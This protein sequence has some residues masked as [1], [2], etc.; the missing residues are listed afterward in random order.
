[1]KLFKNLILTL[2]ILSASLGNVTPASA[3]FAS[4]EEIASIDATSPLEDLIYDE[5][6]QNDYF[7]GL[8]RPS[9][10]GKLDLI[11][12][13]EYKFSNTFTSDYGLYMYLFNPTQTEFDYLSEKNKVQLKF[14]LDYKKYG[15]KFISKTTDKEDN[16]FIKFK[17]NIDEDFYNS[18][19]K[20]SRVYDVSSIALLSSNKFN[21]EDYLIGASFKYSG[22]A[23]GMNDN[24]NSTLNCV[25]EGLDVLRIPIEG[26]TK[27]S[28]FVNQALTKQQDLHYVYFAIPTEYE[29]K[30]GDLYS[31]HY[32]YDEYELD[33]PFYVMN[34]NYQT[35]SH[36]S[37][38]DA[39]CFTDGNVENADNVLDYPELEEPWRLAGCWDD[40][41]RYW[42]DP[43]S[44]ASKMAFDA[45]AFKF[46]QSADF[47][48]FDIL[49]EERLFLTRT[50]LEEISNEQ[51]E[52]RIKKYGISKFS[53]TK[54]PHQ[55]KKTSIDDLEAGTSSGGTIISND[56]LGKF[57]GLPE[58]VQKDDAIFWGQLD[59]LVKVEHPEN[60]ANG[61]S[62]YINKYD[63]TK[64]NG[65]YNNSLKNN[66]S[67]YLLRIDQTPYITGDIIEADVRPWNP[68]DPINTKRHGY[69]A[70]ETI[71]LNF[72]IISFTFKNSRGETVLPVSSNP[73]NIIPGL[74]PSAEQ[75]GN[76][77]VLQKVIAIVLVAV[78]IIGIIMLINWIR[79]RHRENV[80]HRVNKILLKNEK[81]KLRNR[82]E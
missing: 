61:N 8:Y 56:K 29:N 13:T 37:K 38:V 30:F 72:T 63:V 28:G 31:V 79:K 82:R 7:Q 68:F 9:S 10:G 64:F 11:N 43:V 44:G 66:K 81:S 51:V 20:S 6:F 24:K 77:N 52:E 12:F 3:A 48:W 47:D 5:K 70:R 1:M 18:L 80:S 16:L 50:G 26:G 25:K 73:I 23:K 78:L 2:S 32:E 19:N 42:N 75:I 55:D 36:N 62:F 17:V 74:T 35:F 58:K 34:V 76:E 71:I 54:K 27:R 60:D 59:S 39:M 41:L 21:A 67:M 33:K 45:N 49:P 4:S 14:G 40:W 53:S 69:T 15:L 57:M 22:Y 46:Q 65:F